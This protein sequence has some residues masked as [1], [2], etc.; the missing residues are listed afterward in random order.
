MMITEQQEFMDCILFT[1]GEFTKLAGG[2]PYKIYREGWE[3]Q[4]RNST[5]PVKI[6]DIECM[7][8]LFTNELFLSYSYV[9]IFPND[10]I[11]GVNEHLHQLIK[12]CPGIYK[13]ATLLKPEILN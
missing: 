9:K 1:P 5:P 4:F 7:N 8:R 3:E 12:H 13:T 10:G 6:K 11:Y 2:L